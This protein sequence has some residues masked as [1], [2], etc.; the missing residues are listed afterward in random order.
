MRA[1]NLALVVLIASGSAAAEAPTAVM[2]VDR[3][4]LQQTAQY[5]EDQT[6]Y[7]DGAVLVS[8]DGAPPARVDAK[9][10]ARLELD[11][12]TGRHRFTV[13]YLNG[14]VY[15]ADRFEAAS[16]EELCLYYRPMYGHFELTTP[17]RSRKGGRCADC[18]TF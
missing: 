5:T 9:V 15:E 4:V 17:D 8:V 1:A 11:G 7:R 10:G 18:P 6:L 12:R 2:C 16:G 13:K 14:R 3:L